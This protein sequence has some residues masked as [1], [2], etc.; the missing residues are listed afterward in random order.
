MTSFSALPCINRDT[1]AR[2]PSAVV[3]YLAGFS[4]IMNATISST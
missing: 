3:A 2:V 4:D 1:P